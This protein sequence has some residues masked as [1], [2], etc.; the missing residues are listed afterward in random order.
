MVLALQNGSGD[1]C[2]CSIMEGDGMP[3][4][5]DAPPNSMAP[6]KSWVICA[7]LCLLRTSSCGFL[8][9][10]GDSVTNAPGFTTLCDALGNFCSRIV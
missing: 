7:C 9:G 4:H 10:D 3:C 2:M 5:E 8:D 1:M 6:I